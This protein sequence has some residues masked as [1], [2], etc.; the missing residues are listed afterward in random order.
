MDAL[1]LELGL[2]A[3]GLLLDALTVSQ[4]KQTLVR[5]KLPSSGTKS[6]LKGRVISSGLPPSQVLGILSTEELRKLC[7]SLPG[8]PVSGNKAERIGRIIGYFANLIT[9]DCVRG[10]IAR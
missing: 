3:W 7:A 6:E 5:K 9:K 10:S 2:H 4:L 1:G 8:V